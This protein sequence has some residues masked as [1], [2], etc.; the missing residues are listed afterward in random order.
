M[1]FLRN[2]P[3]KRKLTVIA[4]LASGVALCLASM[5][6]EIYEQMIGR[7]EMA[8]EFSMLTDVFGGNVASGLTFNEFKSIELTLSSLKAHPHIVAAAVFDKNGKRV[9]EYQREDLK[10][11]FSFPPPQKTGTHF[12]RER[13]DAF[14]RIVLTGENI[15][16]IYISSDLREINARLWHYGII[17]GVV[18]IL[19]SLVAFILSMRLQHI[20]SDPI[21]H[22]AEVA[23]AVA[24]EKDYSVR[25]VKENDDELGRLI[26]GFN[27]MLNQIQTRDRALQEARGDLEKRVEQRTEE[28]SK[29]NS[30]L[31][32]SAVRFQTVWESTHE[33]MRLIDENGMIV[34]VNA[35]FCRLFGMKREELEGAPFTVTYSEDRDPEELQKKFRERFQNQHIEMQ[36]ERRMVLRDGRTVDL[37]VSSTLVTFPGR[38][39][40]LLGLFRD[41]TERKGA[42]AE[43]EQTHRQLLET[44]RQAGMAEVATGVLHNVGNVLN[45]VNVSST[46]VVEQAKKSKAANLSKVVALMEEHAA[47]LGAFITNDLKGKQ[48]PGYLSQLAKHLTTEQNTLLKE[49]E[50]LR[51][52]IEH[53]KDI[54]AM[55]QSYAKVSGVN[56]TLFISDLVEDALGMNAS[57]LDRHGVQIIREYAEVPPVTIDK[58]KVLQVLVNLIR[59][60]KYACDESGRTDKQVTVC[61]ANGD[62]RIK[63]AISDNG[64]GIPQENL[65]RIFNHGFT[66]RKEGHGFGLHSGALAAKEL[67]GALHVRSD[68]VGHGATFI[69]EF[70]ANRKSEEIVCKT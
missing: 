28:L 8:A 24:T 12:E 33:A 6:F 69:L 34:A 67:G 47:D 13:F 19:S 30:E 15:G 53:I 68:G 48:L 36:S 45:S 51:K 18:L 50:G 55:Q 54:V 39:A 11:S 61:V 27:E 10:L 59:N 2:L 4:M 60:A 57:A 21:S 25:A 56:E 22:L 62:G 35:A 14:R 3:I 5:T 38:G 42:A 44:S 7:R 65:I 41:I 9:A 46:L 17:V 37:E 23:H 43:L 66:T 64:V 70:P 29:A 1:R 40:L 31:R 20:I 63:I 49:M 32:D 58:H 26:E 52:N 16:T